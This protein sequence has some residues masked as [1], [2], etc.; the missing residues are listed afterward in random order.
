[1]IWCYFGPETTLPL[2]SAVAT[3]VGCVLLGGRVALA[4]FCR[5]F[6]LPGRR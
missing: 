6:R 1:M 2:A 4:W 5:L 3:A